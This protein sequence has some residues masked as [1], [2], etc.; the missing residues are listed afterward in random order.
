MSKENS[1]IVLDVF[2]LISFALKRWKLV[3]TALMLGVLADTAVY[4]KQQGNLTTEVVKEPYVMVRLIPPPFLNL[5][6]GKPWWGMGPLEFLQG[7]IGSRSWSVVE[8][9]AGMYRLTSSYSESLPPSQELQVLSENFNE[10][11]TSYYLNEFNSTKA[12]LNSYLNDASPNFSSEHFR[13]K[14]WQLQQ[15]KILSV[16]FKLYHL[17]AKVLPGKPKQ[18]MPLMSI[19]LLFLGLMA[20]MIMA[21]KEVRAAT[22]S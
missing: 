9:G 19:A 12:L 21:I 16:K 15:E 1:E 8:D 10:Q 13:Y 6:D 17:E 2:D 4:L 18:L 11:A 20:V 22:R 14:L 3:T 7:K 5:P